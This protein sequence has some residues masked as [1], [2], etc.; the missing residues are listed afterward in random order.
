MT[1]PNNWCSYL[2]VIEVAKMIK[3]SII[4]QITL[5]PVSHDCQIDY[6]IGMDL[7]NKMASPR[8]Y[9]VWG[10]SLKTM[11]NIL[12]IQKPTSRNTLDNAV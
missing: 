2:A 9:A 8:P 10:A 5:N 4:G 3:S 12:N 11:S 6:R 7:R 1:I